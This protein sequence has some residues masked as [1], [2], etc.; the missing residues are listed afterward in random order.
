MNP[1]E[2]LLAN[3]KAPKILGD[4]P[5]LTG[6]IPSSTALKHSPVA[7]NLFSAFTGGPLKLNDF[8]NTGSATIN[9]MAGGMNLSFGNGFG[10]DLNAKNKQI[11]LQTPIGTLSGNFSKNNPGV[12]VNIQTPIGTL[13][14]NF[15]KD[16]P[17]VNVAFPVGK[18]ADVQA[19]YDRTRGAFG[20]LNF[21]IPFGGNQQPS[22]GRLPIPSLPSNPVPE[23]V[24][25]PSTGRFLS[26]DTPFHLLPKTESVDP[27]QEFLKNFIRGRL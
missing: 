23:V 18:T 8:N 9:P 1:F 24:R 15:N 5:Q 3:L 21:N 13:S 19:G 25:P 6:V 7:A 26:G 12:N 4:L 11:G 2:Q 10:V 22:G 17:E 14:G 20:E 16:N 27:D